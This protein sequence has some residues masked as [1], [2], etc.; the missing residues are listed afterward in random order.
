MYDTLG[1][2]DVAGTRELA[3]NGR[4]LSSLIRTAD[5]R[6][7]FGD[8][9]LVKQ[10]LLRAP[11]ALPSGRC[12][13][14]R[15]AQCGDLEC[16]AVSVRVTVVEDCF[17]WSELSIESPSGGEHPATWHDDRDERAFYFERGHYLAT[18]Y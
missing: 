3:I 7:A 17:V 6:L 1:F 16:G 8:P 15:C 18:I 11:S 14:Y 5:K 13:L 4:A 9:G 10:L 12:P 2:V